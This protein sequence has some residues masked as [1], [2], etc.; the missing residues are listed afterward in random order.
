MSQIGRIGGQVLTD[1]LLRAGVDLAFE[2]DL[3]Y[4]DVT[5]RRIGIEDNTPSYDLDVNNNLRTTDLIVDAQADIQ[6][7]RI[8]GPNT[9]STSV[10]GIDVFINGGGELFHDRMISRTGSTNYLLFDGNR[11]SSF[12]NNNIV[13]DP[14]GS[15][16]VL[17]GAN[18]E[19]TGNLAVSGNIAV[20]GNLSK[21]GN[22]ILGDDVIDGEGNV[23]ENDIVDFN[24][25]FSQDLVP[26][27]DNSFDLGGSLGDSTAGRWRAATVI[28][29]T[30][31]TS[32]R[33]TNALISDQMLING[34]ANSIITTQSNENLLLNPDT[35]VTDIEQTRWQGDDITN[36]LNTPLTFA[37]TGI[38]YLRVM[39]DNAFI[40]PA[41]ND[42]E[43]RSSPEVGETRWNTDQQYLECFDGSLW[44]ISIGGSSGTI[45]AADMDDFSNIYTLMLG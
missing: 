29:N 33:P 5:N 32:V 21:Q 16:Q 15:G 18:T 45:T 40:L 8:I 17:I 28:D 1:N 25:P 26:G 19:I 22:L 12:N 35:G 38:G 7:L 34:V 27:I 39:G 3:L 13:F 10:G 20:S 37:G 42:S 11:I 14:N 36:L 30:N 31:I 41:G 43:R 24:V 23:P 6:N 4:L 9:I 44:Q 2:T